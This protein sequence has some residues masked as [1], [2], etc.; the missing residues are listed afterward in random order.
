MYLYQAL[1]WRHLRRMFHEECSIVSILVVKN[2]TQVVNNWLGNLLM[3]QY[4]QLSISM[5]D[6]WIWLQGLW[7]SGK[8]R[9]LGT[10]QQQIHIKCKMIS[11]IIGNRKEVHKS[12]TDSCLSRM[13][14]H[15]HLP[16]R[17]S[18]LMAF[19]W[20]TPSSTK[21]LEEDPDVECDRV[22]RFLPF[23]S[24]LPFLLSPAGREVWKSHSSLRRLRL[25]ILLI[26]RRQ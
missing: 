21:E 10:K 26:L 7:L 17:T 2:K 8:A 6:K 16:N 9:V 19:I 18:P 5:N 12:S 11:A 4:P 24:G 14:C 25:P 22:E 13:A 20:P 3:Q 23:N 15:L 1:V